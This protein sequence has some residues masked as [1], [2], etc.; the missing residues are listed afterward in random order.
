MYS[1]KDTIDV[2]QFYVE[3]LHAGRIA[4]DVD[5]DSTPAHKITWSPG[6]V[7]GKRYSLVDS[8]PYSA[9]SISR[10]LDNTI[11]NGG[12][13]ERS[14][15]I[16]LAALGCLE[17]IERGIWSREHVWRICHGYYRGGIQAV[18]RA[19]R[20]QRRLIREHLVMEKEI[21]AQTLFQ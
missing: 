11:D 12:G 14:H 17:M 8:K 9:L 20:E 3:E 13:K 1:L 6:F 7:P 15:Q 18:M 21:E 10:R 4:S 19:V 2:C 5:V 16:V